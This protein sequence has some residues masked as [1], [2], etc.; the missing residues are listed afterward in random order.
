MDGFLI[1]PLDRDKLADA[2]GGPRRLAAHRGVNVVVAANAAQATSE[3]PH[4]R[5]DSCVATDSLRSQ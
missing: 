1:K 3:D 2:L 4:E 5:K